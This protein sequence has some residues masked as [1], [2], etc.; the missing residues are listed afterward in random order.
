LYARLTS[1]TVLG[2]GGSDASADGGGSWAI[3]GGLVNNWPAHPSVTG[4][5]T[6]FIAPFA[7]SGF[8]ICPALT[9]PLTS[10]QTPALMGMSLE[11]SRRN[12]TTALHGF[13][14]PKPE[15]LEA[16][17]ERGYRDA[18]AW[19]ALEDAKVDAA[20]DSLMGKQRVLGKQHDHKR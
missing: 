4:G 7:G 9:A 18:L 2:P 1:A 20:A 12:A 5:E 14:P 10:L 15:V 8:D 3:D 16:A 19:C 6:L 13:M 17:A 11:N